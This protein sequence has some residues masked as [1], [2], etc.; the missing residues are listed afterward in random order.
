MPR[1]LVNLEIIVEGEVFKSEVETAMQKTLQSL[2]IGEE[3]RI[4]DYGLDV[5]YF[6]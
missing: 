6:D 4:V 2:K 1:F 5:D 3:A